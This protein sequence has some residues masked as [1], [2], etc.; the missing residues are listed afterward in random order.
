MSESSSPARRHLRL[1]PG[2]EASSGLTIDCECCERRHTSTCDDC[3]VSYLVGAE[4]G[5]PVVL[6]E[7]EERAVG[8]LTDAGLVPPSQF[9]PRIATA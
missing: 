4:S 1:L 9:R 5:A 2:S 7:Q 6:D 8:L 3:L